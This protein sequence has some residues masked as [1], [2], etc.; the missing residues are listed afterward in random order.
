M[1]KKLPLLSLILLFFIFAS[2]S[3]AAFAQ[4]G[5]HEHT[6]GDWEH[7]ALSHWKS[8]ECGQKTDIEKHEIIWEETDSPLVKL[9]HLQKGVCRVCGCEMES[10]HGRLLPLLKDTKFLVLFL[11]FLLLALSVISIVIVNL[12]YNLKRAK[13]HLRHRRRRQH[14]HHSSENAAD[15]TGETEKNDGA[16]S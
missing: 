10:W 1:K 7:D 4:E 14:H 11:F 16:P 8:C 15:P 13:R 9:F 6:Y 12:T 2:I 5:I 3:S